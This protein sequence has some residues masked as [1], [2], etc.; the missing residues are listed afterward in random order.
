MA[1]FRGGMQKR[2]RKGVYFVAIA[3]SSLSLSPAKILHLLSFDSTCRR[4]P[5]SCIRVRNEFKSASGFN[6]EGLSRCSGDRIVNNNS[7]R[8]LLA[9][10]CKAFRVGGGGFGC[11]KGVRMGVRNGVRMGVRVCKRCGVA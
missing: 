10:S 4:T 8:S 3:W 9:S 5:D 7:N 6:R 2:S 1:D 11:S